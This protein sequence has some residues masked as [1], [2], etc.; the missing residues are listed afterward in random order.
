MLT[1][2]ARIE[3]VIAQKM[4][5]MSE[6][7]DMMNTKMAKAELKRQEHI[8]GIRKKAREEVIINVENPNLCLS[9]IKL[10]IEYGLK[11]LLPTLYLNILQLRQNYPSGHYY[12]S[13]WVPQ[14]GYPL[15]FL[16]S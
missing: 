2:N 5:L 11:Q 14:V 12:E 13:R 3:E 7:R 1:L 15:L 16:L 8:D 9:E 10:I 6:K 4:F